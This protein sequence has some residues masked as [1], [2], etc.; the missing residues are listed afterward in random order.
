MEQKIRFQAAARCPKI[1]FDY[2]IRK[3]DK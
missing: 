3:E 1:K 2:I